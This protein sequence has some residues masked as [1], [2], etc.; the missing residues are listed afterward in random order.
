[1]VRVLISYTSLSGNTVEVAEI[2]KKRLLQE[3]FQVDLYRIDSGVIP[4]LS[5]YD[6][7]FIGT[8]TWNLGSTP[9][10]MKDFVYEI[11]Y[12]PPQVY[13]FGTGDTQFGGDALFCKA[14]EKLAK[15]YNSPYEALKIEQSPRGS[16]EEIVINWTEGVLEECLQSLVR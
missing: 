2:I 6:L 5:Q 9:E 12:K 15:F 14:A 4:D 7:I 10:E 8:Y 11:G 1:M 3:K 13:V 16:Q